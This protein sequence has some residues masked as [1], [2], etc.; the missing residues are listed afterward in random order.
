MAAKI[1]MNRN[2]WAKMTIGDAKQRSSHIGE[3]AVSR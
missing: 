2:M 3:Y 1:T